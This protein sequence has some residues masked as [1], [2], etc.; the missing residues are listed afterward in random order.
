MTWPHE[1][2]RHSLAS[3]GIKTS[4]KSNAHR[5]PYSI[6]DVRN[7]AYEVIDKWEDED[8]EYC[9]L[10]GNCTFIAKKL[11]EELEKEGYS[12]SYVFGYIGKNPYEVSRHAWVRMRGS[13]FEGIN[14]ENP[15]IIDPT[16]SQFRSELASQGIVDVDL[17]T[18][19]PEVGIYTKGDEEFEWYNP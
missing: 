11:V 2:I 16:I 17:G 8:V 7:I 10:T 12:A 3:R 18:N 4:L 5:K 13:Y 9:K 6:A 1:S 15:V 19:L 14:D